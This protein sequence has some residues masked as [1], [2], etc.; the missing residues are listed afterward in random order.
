[1]SQ[2][3]RNQ[4]I[5][6]NLPEI[7]TQLEG[8][9][10]IAAATTVAKTL[11]YSTE[12]KF[13][14]NICEANELCHLELQG[15]ISHSLT[16][17]KW[18]EIVQVGNF[19][20]ESKQ[21]CFDAM[22]TILHSCQ[23]PNT[24]LAFLIL[25]TDGVFKM[26]L[27]MKGI[28]KM[29]GV[30]NFISSNWKGVVTKKCDEKNENLRK[31]VN[32]KDYNK[33]YAFTGVPT[34]NAQDRYARGIEQIIGGLRGHEDVAYL[35]L[36]TPVSSSRVDGIL[37]TCREVQSQTESFKSFSLT[38]NLQQGKSKTLSKSTTHTVTETISQQINTHEGDKVALAILG[39]TGLAVA[40]AL[41]YPAALPLL[42]A[43]SKAGSAT[44]AAASTIKKIPRLTKALAVLQK[45][46]KFHNQYVAKG[47]LPDKPQKKK[48]KSE[49]D[50]T[51]ESESLSYSENY[52]KSISQSV[53]NAHIEASVEHLKKY[54]S[55]MEEGKATG[56]WEVGC[57]LLTSNDDSGSSAMQINSVLS[58]MESIYEPVRFHDIT[59]LLEDKTEGCVPGFVE[60]PLITANYLEDKEQGYK[61]IAFQHPFGDEFSHLTT[62]LTTKELSCYVNFPMSSIPGISVVDVWPDFSLTPQSH[63]NNGNLLEL[64]HLIY[65]RR[66]SD[67]EVGVPI[68]TFCRHALV[69]GVNGSGKT[70]S[71]L[72]VLDGF[73]SRK[74]PVFVIEPAKTEYVDWA[75]QYNKEHPDNKIKIFIPGCDY[76]AKGKLKPDE[77]HLNPFEV[78]R[79]NKEHDYKVLSHLDKL[80]SVLAAAF[81]T[82]EIL[83]TVI[84][85][86]LYKLYMES[87]W[88][89]D[90]EVVANPTSFPTLKDI[91]TKKMKEL[92]TDLG[93][94]EE[95]TLNISAAIRTRF[96][97]MK[98]GWKN[99]LL[100]NERLKDMDWSELFNT[101][102]V[103]N[104]SYAGDDSD[105]A[106]I[107]ALLLQFLYEYRVAES[108]TDGYSF[109]DNVCKHL[110]VVEEAHRVMTRCESPELPQYRSN[111]M[112]ASIL[113]EVRAYGQGIMVVDQ[114]P[115]R[116][117]EDAVKNTNVKII[118]KIVAADDARMVAESMGLS[119]E[120]QSVI[121]KLSIGQAVLGGLNS[122]DVM[123]PHASDIFIAQLR[124]RK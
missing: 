105:K 40:T 27:G 85:R 97:S 25:G 59:T 87:L 6:S 36:A 46:T 70:N 69:A 84:E 120:Q 104:L 9:S 56:M 52:S 45:G 58:G 68:D 63:D 111:Q 109:D 54:A 107:M 2:E 93:Y 39:I 44:V 50:S 33:C 110:V 96:N 108:E 57:Y 23:L 119:E 90:D 16:G 124:K 60:R 123:S 35:V 13:L 88:I 43:A 66:K 48:D 18:L 71:V 122:A 55:R 81:P 94:A 121:P 32:N 37:S 5:E 65:N 79:L 74:R 20:K 17:F 77:L 91:N 10:K 64:G 98:Y 30:Q 83:P 103:I 92:M 4:N 51:N 61:N 28:S 3:V 82:Q 106:F 80:K 115:S 26:Y 95:N 24:N 38:E 89:T 62:L 86:L 31:F 101:P 117:I 22:Q 14:E 113:S 102:C 53:T 7:P 49:S 112:F 116:L 118:H 15:D 8:L 19:S 1:M 67:V 78:I 29:T 114:V 100:N 21:N 47:L 12:R 11:S 42:P 76:Y 41:I 72:S 73:L 75:I 34:M 99:S